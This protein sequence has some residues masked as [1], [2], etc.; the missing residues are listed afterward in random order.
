M[1]GFK[2]TVLKKLKKI[3]KNTGSS[4]NSETKPTNKMT[5]LPKR[6]KL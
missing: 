1:T 2:I 4:M 6:L 5:T 3:F